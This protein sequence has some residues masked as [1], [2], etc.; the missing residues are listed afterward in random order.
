MAIVTYEMT[1]NIGLID[2]DVVE[3]DLGKGFTLSIIL[4]VY[5]P[6]PKLIAALSKPQEDEFII[7]S[8]SMLGNIEE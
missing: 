3:I 2:N 5:P 7:M 8:P 4:N 6:D 1:Q